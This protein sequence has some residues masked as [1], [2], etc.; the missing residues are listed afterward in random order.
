MGIPVC[1]N[2]TRGGIVTPD[3]H[4]LMSPPS[5]PSIFSFLSF[6][7]VVVPLPRDEVG[8]AAKIYTHHTQATLEGWLSI[9]RVRQSLLCDST[10]PKTIF[11]H[12]NQYGYYSV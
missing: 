9:N 1:G 4:R 2:P 5:P 10:T 6:L 12:F 11:D 8:F 7:T 3:D